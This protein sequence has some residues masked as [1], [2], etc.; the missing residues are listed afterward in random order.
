MICLM[1]KQEE[2]YN[3]V[4]EAENLHR[5]GNF[6]KAETIYRKVLQ[7]NPEHSEALRLLGLLAHQTGN[8]EQGINLI[9]QAIN[10][11]PENVEAHFN[12]GIIKLDH[13]LAGEAIGAFRAALSISPKNY[14]CLVNLGNAL[15]IAE[16]FSEAIKQSNLA[17]EIDPD[18]V[19]ALSNLGNALSKSGKL[20]D[21]MSILRRTVLLRPN[22]SQ[23]FNN[24]G[25]IEQTI[26]LIES[27]NHTYEE[28]L[29][30]NPQ[31]QRAERNLL[32]NILNLPNQKSDSLFEVRRGYGMKYNR[33]NLDS[34]K[35]SNRNKEIKRK[36]RI[37]YLSSDFHAHP[38]GFNLLPLIINHD[39]EKVE[40]FI[41]NL[42]EKLDTIRGKF[43]SYADHWRITSNQT[44]E[45]VAL[46]IEEDNIDIL[47]SLA[48]RFNSNQ[49]TVTAF[50]A[51]PIQVSFHDCST[52]GLTEMDFW[53]TDD[54]LHPENTK[55]LFTEKLHR[56]PILYQYN[57]PN[58]FPSISRLPALQNGFIT[59]GCFNKPEKIN[60]HV[61][62][63]WADVLASIPH[64]KLFLKYGAYF[65]DQV[66][67]RY[68]QNKFSHFGVTED[69][70]IFCGASKNREEHLEQ[71]Q[72][73]DI[74][75]DPFPF[76]GATTTFEALAMGVPI[77]T[78]E[79]QYFVGRVAASLLDA[80]ELNK[81]IALTRKE[82]IDAAKDLTSD[83]KSLENLRCT[84]REKLNVSPLCQGKPY[85]QSIEAAYREM[86]HNWCSSHD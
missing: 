86:W 19:E 36:L 25:I 63:L 15:V 72:H 42:D 56:L 28:A 29:R 66:L 16:D 39:K 46:K 76:N 8:S 47:I 17:L 20:T 51:A 84:L 26:G 74:A 55:E 11:Q 4:T 27:A 50:R 49:P 57:P 53:L 37:G 21:A 73:I 1:G 79:G 41:Y 13:N 31:C 60:H 82:Y 78:L 9:L 3:I 24:L 52:S 6:A 85:A 67:I 62:A 43:K 65:D 70:L 75:L 71:Y 23:L 77:I 18:N 33:H 64:S 58:D 2:K 35:F 68:W 12:L 83:L 48:G 80:L 38:V 54:F 5:A 14:A 40:V 22:D 81:L 59:F 69:R 44:D 7:G 30:I 45:N 34:N 32:I 61:I 10:A